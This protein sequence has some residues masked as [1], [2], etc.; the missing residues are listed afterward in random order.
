MTMTFK[1]RVGRTLGRTIYLDVEGDP[2]DDIFLGI[3]ESKDLADYIVE[4]NNERVTS[5]VQTKNSGPNEEGQGNTGT[6]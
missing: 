4:L 5:I 3:V 1:W 6:K 2:K